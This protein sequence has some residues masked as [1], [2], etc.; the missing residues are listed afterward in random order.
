MTD[1]PAFGSP[2][3]GCG[4]CCKMEVCGIGQSV[5]PGATAPCPGLRFNGTAYR[6]AVVEAEAA[7][8][9]PTLIADA[10]GIGKGCC[11]DDIL[12][13]TP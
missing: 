12:E 2:C 4:L 5:F 10:L 8:G 3:N 6:C 11:S 9:L 13:P 1:K 7:S